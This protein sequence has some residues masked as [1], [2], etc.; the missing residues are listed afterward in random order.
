MKL[1][2][3]SNGLRSRIKPKRLKKKLRKFRIDRKKVYP[4]CLSLELRW[5]KASLRKQPTFRDATTG[6]PRNDVEERTQK[7]HTDDVLLRSG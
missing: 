4:Y 1:N 2:I 3:F 7:F 5:C 6:F